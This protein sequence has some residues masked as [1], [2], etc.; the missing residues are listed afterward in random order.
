[1]DILKKVN[2]IITN[3]KKKQ[4]KNKD[5]CFFYNRGV[6]NFTNN[7]Y[8]DAVN[9]FETA[10]TKEDI[11]PQVY[12]NL[13]LVHQNI[14]NFDKAIEFYNK[15]LEY[16]PDD[17]DA[18]YNLAI[19]TYSRNQFEDAVDMF[20]KLITVKKEPEIIIALTKAYIELECI[21]EIYA[22]AEDL[23]KLPEPSYD[24]YFEVA[25]VLVAQPKFIN[26][27][28]FIDKAISMLNL[29]LKQDAE[30]EKYNLE[31]S[32]CCA[33]KHDWDSSIDL[34][35]KVLNQ[36]EKSF[37]ANNQMGIIF[38]SQHA[39]DTAIDYFKK[40]LKINSTTN[41]KIYANLAYAYEAKGDYK[42]A[43]KYF[44]TLLFKFPEYP[45][46]DEIENHLRILKT[47]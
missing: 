39:L 3:Y 30:N 26:G 2:S 10:L 9:D 43:I 11:Q 20:T 19:S 45:A 14:G 38:Y 6:E 41:S 17:Y 22:L 12:Y 27:G 34:C 15:F 42:N 5:F 21:E 1:M 13:G 23:I 46:F 35:K 28:D 25:K 16:S 33:K 18:K 36:N 29:L 24:L 7:K 32:I 47:L 37:D 4:D 8:A 44:S 40:A 31:L